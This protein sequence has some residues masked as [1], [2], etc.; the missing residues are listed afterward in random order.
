[1]DDVAVDELN[2]PDSLAVDALESL[3]HHVQ[4]VA[5]CHEDAGKVKADGLRLWRRRFTELD[6]RSP[7]AAFP[8][9]QHQS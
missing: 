5:V 2:G 1:M 7:Y 8:D 9:A 4:H 6:D 3:A